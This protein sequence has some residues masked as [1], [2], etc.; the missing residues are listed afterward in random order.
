MPPL[1]LPCIA[2]PPARVA[3]LRTNACGTEGD[4]TVNSESFLWA[5]CG[6]RPV[7]WATANRAEISHRGNR[8]PVAHDDRD[9]STDGRLNLRRVHPAPAEPGDRSPRPTPSSAQRPPDRPGSGCAWSPA[10]TERSPSTAPRAGSAIPTTSTCWSA[11]RSLADVIV[12][13]AGTARGEGYG[14]PS[15]PGQRI[16]VV[17]NSGRVDL[18]TALFASGA[19]FLIAPVTAPIDESA[20]DVLRA[21]D[22]RVDLRRGDRPARHDRAGRRATCRPRAARRST[23]PCSTADLDRRAR[24]HHLAAHR[25]RRRPPADVRSRGHRRP[26]RRSPTC[27]STTTAS[28]SALGT[29]ATIELRAR[30]RRRRSPSRGA[31]LAEQFELVLE[32]GGGVEVLVHRREPQVGDLVEQPQP[33][34]HRQTDPTAG[35]LATRPAASRLRPRP[36][37]VRSALRSTGRPFV[38]ARTPQAILSRSNGCDRAVGLDHGQRHFLDPLEGGEPVVH[39]RHCRRRRTER[40]LL[41]ETRVDDFGVVGL[42]G[43]GNAPGQATHRHRPARDRQATRSLGSRICWPAWIVAPPLRST[44]LSR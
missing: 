32:V 17:T 35:D 7:L 24:S 6:Q 19:G 4:N 41:G 8:R 12:V 28:C 11:L 29:P 3:T 43:R 34:E 25:R 27:W 10:S 40:A 23:L 20:C 26:V 39:V 42:A 14:P 37:A 1:P 5:A 9:G 22:E 36:S 31:Q 13:G 21:G 16:G 15:K 33:I 30:R 38:A 44:S 2:P 18:T